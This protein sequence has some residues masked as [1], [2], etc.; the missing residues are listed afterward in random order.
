MTPKRV[1]GQTRSIGPIFCKEGISFHIQIVGEK[2]KKRGGNRQKYQKYKSVEGIQLGF[3]GP[4]SLQILNFWE[5]IGAEWAGGQFRSWEGGGKCQ[6]TKQHQLPDA[7]A[8]L[9]SAGNTGRK[10][11]IT[12]LFCPRRRLEEDKYFGSLGG[13][14]SGKPGV[15]CAGVCSGHTGIPDYCMPPI[16]IT[17]E[18]LN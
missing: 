16:E 13:E 1:I 14:E 12:S 10:L 15:C 8:Q 2:A 9:A 4:W 17:G 7:A 5:L 6:L 18:R 11:R 3:P